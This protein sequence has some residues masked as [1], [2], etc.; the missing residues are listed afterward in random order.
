MANPFRGDN[1]FKQ[2]PTKV[3][4][5]Q[6]EE[7]GRFGNTF[8]K[9]KGSVDNLQAIDADP[10]TVVDLFPAQ[11]YATETKQELIDNVFEAEHVEYKKEKKRELRTGIKKEG[12][13]TDTKS[14]DIHNFH[15]ISAMYNKEISR[16]ELEAYYF[17]HPELNHT[18]LFDEYTNTRETLLAKN[19][20]CYVDGKYAYVFTYQSGNVSK[21]MSDLNRDKEKLLSAIGEKQWEKQMKFLR[22]VMPVAKGFIGTDKI[23]LLPHSNFSK[24]LKISELKYGKPELNGETSLFWAFK[25]WMRTIPPDM[26]DKS[27]Y[28]EVIDYYLDNKAIPINKNASKDQQVREEKNAINIRQR[29]KEDGDKLFGIFL[30]D[31]LM[32]DDQA[33]ISHLWNEKFNSIVEPNLNKIPVC[34]QMAATFKANVPFTLNPTQRQAAAFIMEKMSGLLAYGVGVGKTGAAITCASQAF[35]N[36]LAKKFLFVVPTNTYDKWIGEIQGFTDKETG[37]FMQGLL[38]Q[39]PPVVGVYNLNP[40]IVR[41]K[42]KVYSKEDDAKFDS[43]MD[44]IAV[45]KK[46]DKE[47]PTEKDKDRISKVYPLNW[48]GLE[49]QYKLYYG[50]TK[51]ASPKSFTAFAADYLKEEYNYY[52]YTLGHLRSFPDGTIFV[53]TEVGLQRLGVSEENK[54]ELE[55]RLYQILSQGEK[56]DD[57]NERDVAGL[58]LRIEQTVSSSLK[59]AKLTLEEFGIDWA[60]FDESHYYK[61]LFTFVKG[62]ITNEYEDY[63]TGETKYK[64]DKSKYE[65]KSGAYPSSRALS[66]FVVSHYIQSKN[67]NRNVIQLTA[68]PFTNSPLEVFSMLTLTN[69]KTLEDM[70]LSNMVDFFDTFMRINYDI[71]YTPQKTV[72]KD[73]VLT[74]YNNLSQLRQVIYSLMDKKD[75]GAGLKRPV[76]ITYPSIAEGRETTIPMTVEQNDLTREVKKYMMGDNS[77]D[78]ICA[79]AAKD[80]LDNYDFDGL[81][82][83]ALIASWE[84][85]TGMEYSG[86]RE[87][88]ADSKR[89]ALIKQIR[90]T[91][92]GG[93]TMDLEDLSEEESAGV[94]ILRG[95]SMMRQITL[96]PYLYYKACSKAAGAVPVMPDYNDYIHSSPKLMYVM[97]CIQSVID[98][99][100]SRNEKVSGQVIYMNA[101]VEYFPLIKEYLVKQLHLKESQI[102]IVSGGMS[103]AAK[104]N[105]KAAF[106]RGDILVLI[107]SSTIA[108]GVDLQNNATTLYNCYYDWNPTDAAQIEGR[109]WRQGN[110]FAYVRIVYPQ[111][112]NS[113][114][115]VLFEYLSSKTLRINEIW[116]R[117][118]EVQ[119]LDLRDFNPKELQ[120]RLITDP[121]E[122]AD[123]EILEQSDSIEA[124]IIYFENRRELLQKSINSFRKYTELRPKAIQFLHELSTRKQELT[125]EQAAGVQEKKISEI[126]KKHGADPVKM[127]DEIQKYTKDRYD[128]EK[129]PDGR[130]TPFVYNDA[131]PGTLLNDAKKWEQ[132][133]DDWTWTDQATYGELYSGRYQIAETLREFRVNY[134]D[135]LKASEKILKPMGLTFETAE[136]PIASFDQN[137]AELRTELEELQGSRD[138]RIARIKEEFAAAGGFSK[139]V[140]DRVD[141]FA[142]ANEKYLSAILLSP[143]AQADPV[144]ET[145]VTIPNEKERPA[146]NIPVPAESKISA[147]PAVDE[148]ISPTKEGQPAKVADKKSIEKQIKALAMAE[149]FAAATEKP[150]IKK[151]I[152]ALTIALR[153]AA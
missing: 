40:V 58:L 7:K 71:K 84:Q 115:P 130:Y 22:D 55:S 16:D 142:S 63:K 45:I 82:D 120:K 27:N 13:V 86:E 104:E 39:L 152:N 83:E 136:N 79:S 80:D 96:S 140:Q 33:R 42:L 95:L 138:A 66:A 102:G 44:A 32:P 43:I 89:E 85:T 133:I 15:A 37:V 99:H 68:T 23:T 12:R 4:G 24:E 123:W 92:A 47:N 129:D 5:E 118:S 74:G 150:K 51:S 19:L 52:T 41:E 109:I 31:E 10:V 151:Q 70:G 56:S 135:M 61:K 34:F 76:K 114:D 65:L 21:K 81:D 107:G 149:K 72:V 29:T 113:A 144:L 2:N 147:T 73:V 134:S 87:N 119:E 131:E 124:K 91:K 139:T 62:N 26:F 103:K 20:I 30:A 97:G 153:F 6:V 146:E 121:E 78:E 93:L 57:K 117:S 105:V 17:T 112:Y 18:L 111:C 1:F 25:D 77:Y 145:H 143:A 50:N 67:N 126:V 148:T 127:A 28:R 3:L 94:R 108:V 69:Y 128:H 137:L 125:R 59:N 90:G 122:K 48:L 54:G 9:V 35:Y 98:Y 60:C 88:L 38:P 8:I 116:N 106:L 132:N 75:A 53:T 141:E 11:N 14:Q 101:G 36:G 46:L 49:E 64:R 110:R 100:R